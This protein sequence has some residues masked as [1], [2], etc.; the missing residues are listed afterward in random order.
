MIATK[1]KIVTILQSDTTLQTLLSSPSD[2]GIYPSIANQKFENFPCITYLEISGGFRTVPDNAEDLTL[3]FHIYSKTSPKHIEDIYS[4]LNILLNYYRTTDT[5]L[6]RWCKQVMAMDM[7]ET[8]RTL[9][10]K[11]IRYQLWTI[12]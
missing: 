5:P 12:N 2:K 10:H 4:R 3:E 6:I 7:Q 1:A 11:V 8:D 9:F